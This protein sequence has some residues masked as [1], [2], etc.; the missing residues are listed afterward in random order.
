MR[1]KKPISERLFAKTSPQKNGCWHWT[2]Y[3]DKAGYGRI[4]ID[5]SP[6]LAH[7]IAW[8]VA[9]NEIADTQC[10]C[11]ACDNPSCINPAHL[12][13]GSHADNMRDMAN[14]GRCNN[15]KAFKTHCKAGHLLGGENIIPKSG[16]RS[17]LICHRHRAQVYA[18]RMWA[19]RKIAAL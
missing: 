18:K 11:H 16:S 12:F 2:G 7:R 17:C 6:R 5:Q 1:K 9:G 19:E 13:I 4:G 10:V 8:L 14:K 15:G 3:I